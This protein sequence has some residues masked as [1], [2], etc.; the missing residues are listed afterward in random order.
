MK[1]CLNLDPVTRITVEQALTH[2]YLIDLSMQENEHMS[3]ETNLLYSSRKLTQRNSQAA[4]DKNS[5]QQASSSNM[6]NQMAGVY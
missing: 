5:E 6:S 3:D 2:P 1:A 4:T